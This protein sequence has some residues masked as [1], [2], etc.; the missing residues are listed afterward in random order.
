MLENLLEILKNGQDKILYKINNEYITYYQ[1][2][3][4]VLELSDNLKKQGNSPVILY[5][6]KSINQFISI[7]ACVVAKRCY[8]PIDLCMPINRIKEII[9]KTNSTLII[10]NEFIKLNDMEVLTVEEINYIYKNSEEQF[11]TNNDI[12]YII[13]TSG[14]TGNSKGVPIAY[15]NLNHFIEWIINLSEFNFCDNLRVLS[16]ANFSFDLSVMDIYFSL[17][18]G[19]TIVAIDDKTKLDLKKMYEIIQKEKINFLINT[20]TFM[21]LLLLDNT[22]NQKTFSY[23]KY[24]FFCGECL[25]VTLAKKIRER[26]PNV[27]IINA[28]GPTEATCCVTLIE[29]DKEMFDYEYLP[30]GKLNTSAVKIELLDNEIIL[31]GTSVFEKYLDLDSV[32]CFK[33]NDINCYKTGD[34][35]SINGNYL[36]CNGR[37]D[38]QIKYNGYRIE[39]GDIENNLLKVD[40]IREGVVIAKYKENSNV[41]RMIKAF[42]VLDKVLTESEIKFELLKLIPGYM[43]PKKIIILDKIPIN[44]NGKYDRRKL[45]EL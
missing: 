10:E 22:F 9:D 25:E 37:L 18:K 33:E 31:K 14:S 21:K 34:Y 26:F 43:V 24:A 3:V 39:L 17:Y 16:Q 2:Y 20:P 35:G 45:S 19:G 44:N 29:I 30:V 36:F 32:R 6:Q 40:G 15:D 27:S 41:V 13:F 7:L 38:N 23:I 5:G 4:N 8:I 28:Y 42:V 12:A 1:A 11:I